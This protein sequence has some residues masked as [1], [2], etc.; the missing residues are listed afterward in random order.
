MKNLSNFFIVLGCLL[1]L[2]ALILRLTGFS[3]MVT[4]KAI[5]PSS[6]LILAN[7]SFILAILF[8]K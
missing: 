4:M 8:K 1:I 5:K 2:V 3:F 7:T 6:L